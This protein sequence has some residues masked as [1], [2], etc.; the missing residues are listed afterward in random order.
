VTHLLELLQPIQNSV[1][2]IEAPHQ[3]PEL[4]NRTDKPRLARIRPVYR[5]RK[6]LGEIDPTGCLLWGLVFPVGPNQ[7]A[8]LR[9]LEA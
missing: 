2:D 4:H 7:D 5:G 8:V 9:D 6:A 1:A 3:R